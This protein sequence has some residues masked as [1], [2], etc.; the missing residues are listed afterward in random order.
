MDVRKWAVFV[1]AAIG[2]ALWPAGPS[3]AC[4]GIR[5][6]STDGSVVYARSMEFAE[7]LHS[8]VII[9]PR[10]KAFT[11]VGPRGKP[12]L[13]WKSK[14]AIVGANGYGLPSIVDGTN[15]K[16]VGIGIFY[17]PSYAKYQRL[18]PGEESKALAPWDVPTFL[19]GTCADADEAVKAIK[20][21][22][23]CDSTRKEVPETPPVHYV[24]H[25]AAGRCAV[26]EHVAGEVRVHDNPLGVI[27]NAPTFDWHVTNLRNYVNLSVNN[28]PPVEIKGLIFAP[29]GQGA[30]MLGI[31]GD[32][33]P[34]SRFVRAVAFTQSAEPV[35]T[36]QDG[37][38]QAFHLLNQF[39]IPKG[40]VRQKIPG[41]RPLIEST[42][43]TSA[44]D[45][46]NHR[47]YI[48]TYEKQRVRMVDLMAVDLN[49]AGVKT[50]SLAGPEDIEDV[51][52][53]AK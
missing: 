10:G 12:G 53:Q 41:G 18:P 29:F 14:Y 3:M 46:K 8:D 23:V 37:V 49:A 28:V 43:W 50:V 34:P 7:N 1:V 42:Q 40:A 22:I 13:A 47:Y 21:A 35:A 5:V 24:I 39:D 16:G 15:E 17:F 30:G 52:R 6:L 48:R 45:L 36:A 26:V 2:W 19:L 38:L 32:F 27:T 31:P 44:S 20:G 33:T 4:T 51:T 9:I 25:D 11:S